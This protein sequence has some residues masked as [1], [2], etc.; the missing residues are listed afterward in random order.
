MLLPGDFGMPGTKM[1]VFDG[2]TSNPLCKPPYMTPESYPTNPR[3]ETL[4]PSPEPTPI[5]WSSQAQCEHY[6]PQLYTDNQKDFYKPN[7]INDNQ[8]EFYNM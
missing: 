1:S 6:C 2:F 7:L 5:G 8:R 4:F 3:C